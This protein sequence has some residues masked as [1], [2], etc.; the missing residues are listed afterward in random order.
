MIPNTAIVRCGSKRERF[1]NPDMKGKGS[2]SSVPQRGL[3]S[4]PFDISDLSDCSSTRTESK[5]KGS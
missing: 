5:T 2:F 1:E 3:E 4:V